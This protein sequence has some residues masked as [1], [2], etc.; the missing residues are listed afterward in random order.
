MCEYNAQRTESMNN[1]SA[2]LKTAID[3][4]NQVNDALHDVTS[5]ASCLDAKSD[6]ILDVIGD[7]SRLAA[8]LD[9]LCT[10]HPRYAGFLWAATRNLVRDVIGH[11][12]SSTGMIQRP[13]VKVAEDVTGLDWRQVRRAAAELDLFYDHDAHLACKI[14]GLPY[15]GYDF[16]RRKVNKA[17]SI[18]HLPLR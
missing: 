11:V 8:V 7:T 10:R 6:V 9:A 14:T 3:S 5:R 4:A 13:R 2:A 16:I 15:I 12:S 18:R 17:Y 1:L